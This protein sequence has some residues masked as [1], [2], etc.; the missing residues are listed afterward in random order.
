M[1][2]LIPSKYYTE[3]TEGGNVKKCMFCGKNYEI[4]QGDNA[5]YELELD[6]GTCYVC[7]DCADKY[8]KL[9]ALQTS[10]EVNSDATKD[11]TM[12]VSQALG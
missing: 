5:S 6:N 11:T 4:P 1:K 12:V 2:M 8:D 10:V 7:E 3:K 9:K